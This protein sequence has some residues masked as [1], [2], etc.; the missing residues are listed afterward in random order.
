MS[1]TI[2]LGRRGFL[3][4]TLALGV[5]SGFRV[6]PMSA[7]PVRTSPTPE[8]FRGRL[9]GPIVSIPTP[10]TADFK[11]DYDGLRRMI[12]RAL[13]KGIS[14]FDLTYGDSQFR[15]L[16]YEEIKDLT[17]VV[18]EA[19]GDK[20]MTIAGSGPWWTARAV[21][22]ARHAESVGASAL[23]VM[24]P[25]SGD[26]DGYVKHFQEIARATRLPLVLRGKLSTELLARLVEIDSVVAMK[27]DVTEAYFVETLI[28]FGHRLNSYSGGSLE[29]FIVGQ[30]YGAVASFDTY[31]TF[32]P[33]IS[34]RF[35]KAVQANDL[36]TKREIIEKYEHP[37]ISHEYSDPFWHATLE[38][39][40]VAK[41][42]L[43]PPQHSFT[44]EEMQKVKAFY[45]KLGIY[46]QKP[47]S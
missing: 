11:V 22:F 15:S 4:A 26:E 2:R 31:A 17:R 21:E 42:Y 35:W 34:L 5:A 13:D 44:D 32:A 25:E 46:P 41:R 18:A 45:D 1:T 6:A 24:L 16:A 19:V 3:S 7:R 9:R 29:W 20:G 8:E 36:D 43:R 39:F 38:Y 33:E 37:L 47:S 14:I 28:H 23:E 40:G 10:F 12:R 27:Q 30:P